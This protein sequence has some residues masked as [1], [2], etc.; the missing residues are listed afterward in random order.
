MLISFNYRDKICPYKYTLPKIHRR[1]KCSTGRPF[2][3]NYGAFTETACEFLD[4]HFSALMKK[5]WSCIKDSGE[6][7]EKIENVGDIALMNALLVISDVIGFYSSIQ[8]EEGLTILKRYSK[9][10]Q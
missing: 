10:K 2:I 6:F 3:G 5:S 1:F 4:H 9:N 8:D 7:L